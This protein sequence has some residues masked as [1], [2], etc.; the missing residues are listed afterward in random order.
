[1]AGDL[2]FPPPVVLVSEHS[3]DVALGE[4]KFL[5]NGSSIA[6]HCSGYKQSKLAKKVNE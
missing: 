3:Q 5:G 4:S 2:G 6:V 1:M